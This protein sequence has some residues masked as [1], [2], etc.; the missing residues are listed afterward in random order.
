MSELSTQA[1]LGSVPETGD[2]A[3]VKARHAEDVIVGEEIVRHR[4]LSRV[5][6]WTVATS[7]LLA[8]ITGL[9]IWTPIFGWMAFL[10]GGLEVC[11]WLHPWLG[12]VFFASSVAMFAHWAKGMSMSKEDWAWIGPRLFLYMKSQ[13][14]DSQV[15]KYN[16]GQKIFFFSSALSA[17]ALF[18]TRLLLCFPL[19]F[20]PTLRGESFGLRRVALI[21]LTRPLI[22]CAC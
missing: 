17:L 4:L 6:H 9:P 19:L 22:R 18:L 20:Y 13:T 12:I 11:R 8:L 16:G 2:T 1:R 15:G 7:M 10:V 21:F 3:V 5:I 14:D